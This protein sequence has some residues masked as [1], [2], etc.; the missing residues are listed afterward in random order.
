MPA[1]LPASRPLLRHRSTQEMH[2][3]VSALSR[4]SGSPRSSIVSDLSE[5]KISNKAALMLG[6]DALPLRPAAL[7]RA[8]AN[9]PEL[10]Q[11]LDELALEEAQ[12]SEQ[13]DVSS[14]YASHQRRSSHSSS[15]QASRSE[16]SWGHSWSTSASHASTVPSS[17]FS[18]MPYEATLDAA[19]VWKALKKAKKPD[20]AL[21]TATLVAV[22]HEPYKV[23][24]LRQKYKELYA[25]DLAKDIRASTSGDFRTALS[26]LIDGPHRSA[27]AV[28]ER[29][30]AQFFMDDKLVA[31]ALFGKPADEIKLIKLAYEQQHGHPL[32]R[33]LETLYL[34]NAATHGTAFDTAGPSGAFGRVCIRLLQADRAVERLESLA[35]MS[36]AARLRRDAQLL[37]DVG[38]LYKSDRPGG[39][40]KYLDQK[41]LVELVTTRSDLY[42]AELS[43]KFYERH[44]KDITE[45]VVAK[46]RSKLMSAAYFPLNLVCPHRL[47]R[48]LTHHCKTEAKRNTQGYAISYHLTGASNKAQRDAKLLHD[49]M[50]GFKTHNE[51]LIAR[52][53]RIHYDAD[54][55]HLHFVKDV[56]RQRYGRELEDAVKK[57]T[58]GAYRELLLRIVE[59]QSLVVSEEVMFL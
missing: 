20:T 28:L 5:R 1:E 22:S 10:V 54:P 11:P 16:A 9:A 3:P 12:V 59:G 34:S 48:H 42:L 29:H 38:D 2:S 45:L 26:R 31:E 23:H 51:R 53:V 47:P 17:T 14:M 57:A 43:R 18:Q 55:R 33:A 56:F 7:N 4:I 30:D 50:S 24:Q 8:S 32:Q 35:T 15:S 49:C 25:E 40:Q 19:C 13:Y 46:D 41:L 6:I 27:A 39:A 37:Q 21:L 52:L 44:G 36:S 58:R